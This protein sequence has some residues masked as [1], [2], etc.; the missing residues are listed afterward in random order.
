MPLPALD[1][2][3]ATLNRLQESYRK[4]YGD[5]VDMNALLWSVRKKQT[6]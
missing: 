3:E 2:S 4:Q 1:F 6:D 5:T